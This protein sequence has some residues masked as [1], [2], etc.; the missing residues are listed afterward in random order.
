VDTQNIAQKLRSGSPRWSKQD[1]PIRSNSADEWPGW[2]M[3]AARRR[4]WRGSSRIS[5]S[6][7]HAGRRGDGPRNS[8]GADHAPHPQVGLSPHFVRHLTPVA[9][10]GRYNIAAFF[11]MLGAT[12]DS[13]SDTEDLSAKSSPT[14]CAFSG[15]A[16][17][18]AA[19]RRACRATAP[20]SANTP[21]DGIV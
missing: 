3:L 5:R 19:G 20:R 7:R 14:A 21:M 16:M 1:H 10:N 8:A 15:P 2:Y 9:T 6:G 4:S 13:R 17:A 12:F 18:V 11:L